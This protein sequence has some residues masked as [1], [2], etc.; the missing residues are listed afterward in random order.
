MTGVRTS[1]RYITA[2]N[3][4]A[5]VTRRRSRTAGESPTDAHN[6]VRLMFLISNNGRTLAR[7]AETAQIC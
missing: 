1:K 6:T 7:C 5:P 3:E 4:F 2:L